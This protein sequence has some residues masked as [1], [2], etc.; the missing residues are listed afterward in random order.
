MAPESAG[1]CVVG[2]LGIR[3]CLTNGKIYFGLYYIIQLNITV[4]ITSHINAA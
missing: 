1:V 2:W 4:I 3:Y